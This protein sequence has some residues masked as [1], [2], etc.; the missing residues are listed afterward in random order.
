M[1]KIK[2]LTRVR[3][4]LKKTPVATIASLK[5]IVG[6]DYAYLL[7]ENLV[8]RGEL[9]RIAKGVYS[10]SDDP[11]LAVFYFR[12][13]YIG[14]QA[15][16]SIHGLWE[17]ETNAVIVT[18]QNVRAGLRPVFENNVLVRKIAPKYLFGFEHREYQ[19]LCIPVSDVEKT[20]ID[21]VYFRQ[22]ID[23][24]VLKEF[25]VRID[26]SK[27]DEYLESYPARF[28]SAVL[29]VLSQTKLRWQAQTCGCVEV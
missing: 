13:A 26:K 11:T 9:K 4:F 21:M 15:A 12:P 23:K 1:G 29:K 5:K 16:L 22:P 3:D 8:K 27:L 14:L 18:S 28:R 7:A 20:F 10:T 6:G 19:S 17:Q 2:H 25:R 24:D